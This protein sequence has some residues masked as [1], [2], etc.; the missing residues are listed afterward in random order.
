MN[1]RNIEVHWDT[2]VLEIVGEKEVTGV[3]IKNVKDL[4]EKEIPISGFF[5][6]I[7][8]EPNTAIFKG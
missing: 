4:L 6:A 5:V 8:H 7:G 3:R 2:V 1:S